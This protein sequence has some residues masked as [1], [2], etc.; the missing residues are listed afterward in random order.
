MTEQEFN[1]W[2]DTEEGGLAFYEWL[3]ETYPEKGKHALFAAY[4]SGD[5][6]EY[7]AESLGVYNET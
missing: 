2:M 1:D 5:Y 3:Y 4:E 6:V 7:Y